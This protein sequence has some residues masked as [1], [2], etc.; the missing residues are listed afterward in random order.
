MRA[1]IINSII[2]L[3]ILVGVQTGF[4]NKTP[5]PAANTG[6]LKLQCGRMSLV[7]NSQGVVV[8]LKDTQGSE[9]LLKDTPS[10]ILRLKT[11]SGA[12]LET[13]R[14]M[15]WSEKNGD[16]WLEL[17]F[18][19]SSAVIRVKEK[20][21][22]MTLELTAVKGQQAELVMW[23]PYHV[24]IRD[25]IAESLGAVYDKEFAIGVMALNIKTCGGYKTPWDSYRGTVATPAGSGAKLQAHARDRTRPGLFTY[26]KQKRIHVPPIKEETVI[27]TKIALY[28]TAS[29]DLLKLIGKIERAEGLPQPMR[30][31][32]WLKESSY[33]TSSKLITNFN[34]NTFDDFLNLADAA[35]I[36]CIYNPNV[37]KTWGT[38]Q[39]DPGK[40]PGGMASLK[41][42]VQKARKRGITLG[43]HTLTN[44]IQVNDPLVTPIPHPGLLYAGETTIKKA[45]DA[46]ATEIVLTDDAPIMAYDRTGHGKAHIVRIDDELIEF[47]AR[48]SN[49]PWR[50]TGC[51][52]GAF[53]TKIAEHK[54]GAR[55]VKMVSHGYGVLLP[56]I[57]L[58]DEMASRMAKFFNE[59]GFER[60]SF[61]GLEG[62]LRTGQGRYAEERFFKVFFDNLKNKNIIVNSSQLPHFA[63]HYT[64]N[65]SWGEPWV[66][67]FRESMLDHRLRAQKFLVRNKL[68][69]KL[70]QFRI[71][72]KTTVEDINWV[73][74]LCAGLDSGVDFYIEPSIFTKNPQGKE[75]LATIK[76][77]ETARLEGIFT[78]AEKTELRK[79]NTIFTLV[80]DGKK[81]RLKFVKDWVAQAR[82]KQEQKMTLM[83][84]MFG[85]SA[86]HSLSDDFVHVNQS[87][88]PG[89][90][91]NANWI[92]EN[93]SKIQPLQF[94]MRSPK[95]N[96]QLIKNAYFK[97]GAITCPIPFE[98]KAGQY[99][100]AKGD[101][102]V[103]LHSAAGKVLDKKPIKDLTLNPGENEIIFNNH[104]NGNEPGPKVIINFRTQFEGYSL[105]TG[106]PVSCSNNKADASLVNDGKM[107]Y[108]KHHW[109]GASGNK[110]WWRVDLEQIRSLKRIA[111]VP[112]HNGRRYYQFTVETSRNGKD[113]IT[114]IDQRNNTKLVPKSGY[115]FNIKATQA[116]YIRV[117]ML[118]HS[119]NGSVHLVEVMAFE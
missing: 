100:V 82:R 99:L 15:T 67:G 70:G 77:W 37:F 109:S 23:G 76:R 13:P 56:S 47:S 46:K 63:W 71:G 107:K 2:A 40:F 38:Y 25:Q 49:R 93:T 43:T 79:S 1:F 112:Y 8:S 20:D 51:K 39:V 64:S 9:H 118:K 84:G 95:T 22:F 88:E 98:L 87:R 72:K 26:G 45:L 91:T 106:K 86:G 69:S 53:R 119:L 103:I 117:N 50:L 92:Y 14:S 97:I 114:T 78:Q 16:K 108:S 4:C 59:S 90:P 11:F 74:G 83:K 68:P 19:E 17:K 24:N 42:C 28:G 35:G 3:N 73:M 33:A 41:K 81:V 66:G 75:L 80:Q 12:N 116:R 113:W 30:N 105:T 7:L 29:D 52:R 110:P 65:E 89:Q 62:C 61:D 60:L 48:S 101:G 34:E 10:P 36:S 111:I 44:F 31:G 55:I 57:T 18:K 54:S 32:K 58:Q 102:E 5:A 6:N 115:V 104:R 27:G 21:A 85:S 94:T 96:I